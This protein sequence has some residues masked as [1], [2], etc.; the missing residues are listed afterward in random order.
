MEHPRPMTAHPRAAELPW[1]AWVLGAAT[2]VALIVGT[3]VRGFIGNEWILTT[4]NLGESIRSA[5]PLLVATAVVV[6]AGRWPVGRAWLVAGA[7]LLALVGVL[8]VLFDVGFAQLVNEGVAFDDLEPWFFIGGMAGGVA[9]VLGFGSLAMGIWRARREGWPGM[10]AAAAIAVAVVTALAAAGP[11]AAIWGF[12]AYGSVPST[13]ANLVL[14]STAIVAVGVLA[15]AALRG[16]PA[17]GSI[18]ELIIAAGATGYVVV[19]G[20]TWVLF[21]TSATG[22]RL[23]GSL[24]PLQNA[25]LLLV[26]LGFASGAVFGPVEED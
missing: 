4:H 23:L 5:L 1:Q 14:T 15:V 26:G 20:L 16:G 18:P 22:P 3:V 7:W 19:E 2:V 13:I 8:A 9:H 6:G 24:E 25:A 21:M 10:R 17:R 11:L 12:G